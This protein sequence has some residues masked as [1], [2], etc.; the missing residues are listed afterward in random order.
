MYG[1]ICIGLQFSVGQYHILTSGIRYYK[2]IM[3]FSIP[4]Y[5]IKQV[6][7]PLNSVNGKPQKS[8]NT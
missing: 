1:Q 4:R 7:E 6:D 5:F 8:V 2:L 3:V